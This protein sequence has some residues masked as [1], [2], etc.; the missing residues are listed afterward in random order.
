MSK[1][2]KE[3]SLTL[4]PKELYSFGTEVCVSLMAHE[5]LLEGFSSSID[6]LSITFPHVFLFLGGSLAILGKGYP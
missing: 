2:V 5:P 3:C 4:D 1:E 6:L